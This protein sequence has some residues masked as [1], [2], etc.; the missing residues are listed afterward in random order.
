MCVVIVCLCWVVV[1]NLEKKTKKNK[2]G[3]GKGK[4]REEKRREDIH[5]TQKYENRK[6]NP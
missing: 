1:G 5:I 3:K 2:L 6:A 4:G